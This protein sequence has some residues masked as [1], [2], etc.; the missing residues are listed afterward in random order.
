M[1]FSTNSAE[2]WMTALLPQFLE[3]S[4]TRLAEIEAELRKLD[5]G[6]DP[7][8]VALAVAGMAHKISG[9]ADSFGFA[10]LGQQANI[11]ENTCIR[12]SRP[13]TGPSAA[14]LKDDVAAAVNALIR[15][16]R[17]AVFP[18]AATAHNR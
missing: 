17:Q 11:A 4:G 9:T 2:S 6:C 5:A 1:S 15:A 18:P 10:D 12:L 3:M 7:R 14:A 8:L 13:A 16:L